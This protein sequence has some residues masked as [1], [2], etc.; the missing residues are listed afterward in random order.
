[1]I[2]NE[3]NLRVLS[4]ISREQW[5]ALINFAQE[6]YRYSKTEQE[7]K[8]QVTAEEKERLFEKR[9]NNLIQQLGVPTTLNGYKYLVDSVIWI[10]NNKFNG[11]NCNKE[12][13]PI[14]AEKYN[15]GVGS[16]ESAIRT[17]VDY[18]TKS[19][20]YDLKSKVFNDVVVNKNG[21]IPTK[22]AI[23]TIVIYLRTNR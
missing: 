15:V 22:H 14:I 16:I 8:E 19:K 2:I 4:T 12:V 21:K 6:M 7:L 5:E 3:E 20:G 1:M 13:Y 11:F 18:I 17:C 9:V 10:F 23:S